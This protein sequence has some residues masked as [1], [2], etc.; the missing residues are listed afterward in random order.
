MSIFYIST[1]NICKRHAERLLWATTQL[2]RYFPLTESQLI[3]LTEEKLAILDQFVLRF[4]KLQDLMGTK[5]FP[6][7]LE[8]TK[9][10]GHL[11]TFLDKLNRLEKIGAISSVQQWLILREMRNQFFHDY[12]DDPALQVV[13]LNK[14]YLLVED[15][16]SILNQIETFAH[17]YVI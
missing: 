13:I 8:I 1:L 11:A 7:V 3:D 4:T 16:L 14:A 10:S 2:S 5:L 6:S 9:E 17:P 15:L 12:P